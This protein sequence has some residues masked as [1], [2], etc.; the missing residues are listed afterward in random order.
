M[1]ASPRRDG[2]C[3]EEEQDTAVRESPE[4]PGVERSMEPKTRLCLICRSPFPSAWAGERICR[5]CKSKSSWRNGVV[6]S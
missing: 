1:N 5:H 6:R 2:P 3:E 4:E